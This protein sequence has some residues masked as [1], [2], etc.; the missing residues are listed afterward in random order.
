MTVR[1]DG[2]R[3]EG[4]GQILRTALTLSAWLNAPF[5]LTR[6]RAGRERPGLRAQHLAAIQATAA[7]CDAEVEGDELGS[8]R[9]IFRPGKVK[10]GNYRM[11]VGTA[12]ATTLVAQAAALP[13]SRADGVSRLTVTGGTHVAWAPP[14]DYLRD[15]YSPLLERFGLTFSAALSRYGFYPRGGGVVT[16]SVTGRE[17]AAD[18]ESLDFERPDASDLHI[19]AKAVVSSLPAGIAE[20]MLAVARSRLT[21]REWGYS[22]RIEEARGPQGAY[23]FIRVAG[24]AALGGFT[25][26]GERGKPAESVA[27]EPVEEARGFLEGNASVDARLADQLLLPALMAKKEVS[28][29]TWPVSRHLTTNAETIALFLGPCVRIELDGRVRVRPPAGLP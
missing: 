14:V 7:V 28:F 3:G 19:D 22:E 1:L 4:G 25:G 2:S 18:T 26:L 13:L 16:I 6:I 21:D 9:L 12:G 11:D 17:T 8:S 29:T 20:R 23:L 10:A 15:V 5:E 27:R 24:G